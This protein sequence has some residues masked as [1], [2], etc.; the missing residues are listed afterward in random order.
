MP[1]ARNY[2]CAE[3]RISYEARQVG[4]D[5]WL[6]RQSS[7]PAAKEWVEIG[8]YDNAAGMS[9]TAEMWNVSW[10][11]APVTVQKHDVIVAL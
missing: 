2:V 8:G 7:S 6:S 9:E 11:F 10:V 3:V 4:L 5:R 1:F